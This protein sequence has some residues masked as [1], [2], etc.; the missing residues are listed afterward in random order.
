ME[1][2]SRSELSA[3]GNQDDN[4]DDNDDDNWDKDDSDKGDNDGNFLLRPYKLRMG[5]TIVIE[6]V[7][8]KII[9]ILFHVYFLRPRISKREFVRPSIIVKEKKT[10]PNIHFGHAVINNRDAPIRPLGLVMVYS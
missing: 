3:P 6:S 8:I 7:E 2:W 10:Y 5:K 9:K 1:A 4:R